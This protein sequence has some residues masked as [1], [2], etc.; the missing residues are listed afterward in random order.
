VNR[1]EM[2]EEYRREYIAYMKLPGAEKGGIRYPCLGQKTAVTHVDGFCF[3]QDTW[4]FK[5]IVEIHPKS[6]VDVGS[7]ALLVGIISRLFPTTSFDIR[8]LPVSLPNLTCRRASI[9][10][11][12]V[13][14]GSVELLCSLC[15]I[16]HVGLGRYG[17][18][19]D[20]YGSIKA[21]KEVSRVVEPGGHF[22]ISVPISHTS[23]LCFN[24]HRIF[25]KS[26][27]LA[28]LPEFSVVEE[29]FFYPNPGTEQVLTR[30][31]GSLFCLWCAD[32]IKG[33]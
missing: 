26:Q 20:P 8:P 21:F 3:R 27:V 30:L 4:A 29:A 16:E 28:A 19:L 1:E 24:A 5:R 2:M 7:T 18:K 22:I 13:A 15:V 23:M 6:V 11:L 31:K 14:D 12:P 17:D 33:N 32:L 10:N 9:T 25:T